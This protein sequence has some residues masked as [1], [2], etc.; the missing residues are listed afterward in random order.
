MNDAKLPTPLN[1][2]DFAYATRYES[3]N[4]IVLDGKKEEE[5][6]LLKILD[7]KSERTPEVFA[8]EIKDM[9][10]EK[11]L[12]LCFLFVSE[13]FPIE[14]V[15]EKYKELV[16]DLANEFKIGEGEDALKFERVLDSFRDSSKVD[17]S[18][19]VF[20][21]KYTI[22]FSHPSYYEAILLMISKNG[23]FKLSR[24][25]LSI[26]LIKLFSTSPEV[27]LIVA[28]NYDKLPE[29][30]QNLLSKIPA[31][32]QTAA[33]VADAVAKNFDKLPDNVRNE[34]LRKINREY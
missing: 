20:Y 21:N 13:R 9:E 8:E 23:A 28:I 11:I 33:S 3:S 10:P 32:K 17:T 7:K 22:R 12:F 25:I 16:H 26:V 6:E 1:I 5:E 15:K 24:K 30:V 34:L 27:A 29:N 4:A 14:F 19:D 2:K 31:N 18:Y